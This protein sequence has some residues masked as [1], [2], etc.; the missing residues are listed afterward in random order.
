MKRFFATLMLTAVVYVVAAQTTAGQTTRRISFRPIG[1]DSVN[2]PL[3]EEYQL[4][5]DSCAA[6]LRYS[7]YDFKQRKFFGPFKDVSKM[8]PQVVIAQGSYTAEGLKEGPF[9]LHY[10]NGNLHARGSYKNDK[11]DGKWETFYDTGKP[12]VNFIV[13]DGIITITDAWKT[14]GHKTVDNGDGA[15]QSELGFLYWKGKL[16]GGKPDG[17][18]EAYK[19]DDA[20][21]MVVLSETF[22][23]GVFKKGNGPAGPYEDASRIIL[24]SPTK[25]LFT[26]AEALRVSSVPCGGTKRKHIVNA[27]YRNGLTSLS[28]LIKDQVSPFLSKI[29]L[30]PYD[31]RL[32]FDGVIDETGSI[33]HLKARESFNELL[34]RGIR[35]SLLQ[36][37][38]LQPATADGKP[39]SQKFTITFEF[40][41]GGYKFSYQFLKIE[42]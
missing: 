13:A 26:N 18:W 33:T 3:N 32:T 14:D 30:Q 23:K 39:V 29:D 37:P 34:I 28:E 1:K 17:K 25:F 35:N 7:H 6:I 42:Q 20:S 8:N 36:L 4:I 27:Q 9:E 41:N 19:T 38:V 15:Y 24:F 31:N 5:E 10:L 22:K 40:S 11:F 16:V 2:L 12:A 21:Q